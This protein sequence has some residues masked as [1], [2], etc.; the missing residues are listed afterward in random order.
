MCVIVTL[1]L[2]IG[3]CQCPGGTRV[4]KGLQIAVN[5]P[6]QSNVWHDDMFIQPSK[7]VSQNIK[8]LWSLILDHKWLKFNNIRSV[9]VGI[10]FNS[11]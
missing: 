3:P 2:S 11:I 4:L 9:D 6:S 10:Q 1:D 7:L 8:P 5:P